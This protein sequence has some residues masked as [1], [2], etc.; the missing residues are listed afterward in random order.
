MVNFFAQTLISRQAFA[1]MRKKTISLQNQTRRIDWN[2]P[3]LF[4]LEINGNSEPWFTWNYSESILY[5]LLEP[6]M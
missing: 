3:R 4:F 1:I 6:D 2:L 5:D